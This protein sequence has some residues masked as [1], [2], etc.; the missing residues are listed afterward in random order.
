MS[1]SAVARVLLAGRSSKL[2]AAPVE[3]DVHMHS[4]HADMTHHAAT[5]TKIAAERVAAG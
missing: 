2:L 3:Y 4:K 5:A 1:I